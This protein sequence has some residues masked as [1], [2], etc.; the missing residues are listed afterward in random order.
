MSGVAAMSTW[1]RGSLLLGLCALPSVSMADGFLGLGPDLPYP[2]PGYRE[3]VFPPPQT[4]LFGQPLAPTGYELRPTYRQMMN[5]FPPDPN[6]YGT[7]VVERLV[8]ESHIAS[9]SQLGLA[10]AYGGGRAYAPAGY[11]APADGAGYAYAGYAAPSGYEAYGR[12][13]YAPGGQTPSG[14]VSAP[15]PMR[16]SLPKGGLP[17]Y[18]PDTSASNAAAPAPQ[19]YYGSAAAPAQQ[20][21]YQQ[22]QYQQAS[23]SPLDLLGL[24]FAA[25]Q[26]AAYAMPT[27][28]DPYDPAAADPG[29]AS[30]PMNPIYNRQMV[31][32]AG[33]AR[34]GTII[35][36]TPN[37]FLYLVQPGAQAIRYG[38]GVGRPGFAWRGRKT[39]SRKAEWPDWT[40][41]KEMMARRPDL[42]RHME[43]GMANPLGARALYLG[44]SLYRI[45]GTNEPYTIGTNVSSGCIRMMNQDVI[46]LYD[47]VAVG[48]HVV[49][50]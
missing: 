21:Q 12:Q 2:R 28:R 14:H 7:N 50:L 31:A 32:Y 41:P 1:L 11:A 3:E 48:T 33:S 22:A 19:A 13:A 10:P 39:V 9:P 26:Q 34:P 20:A 6:R 25:P 29:L 38:I 36:D 42:P 47:R 23:A 49:V 15:S 35:I 30:R 8:N 4:G 37:R 24:P 45:H 46:D 18:V 44:S 17:E 27:G 5:Q 16:A 40:P 43:G